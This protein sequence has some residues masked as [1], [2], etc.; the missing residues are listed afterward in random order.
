MNKVIAA[1]CIVVPLLGHV[2]AAIALPANEYACKVQTMSLLTGVVFVQA[3]DEPSAVMV[4]A[5]GNATRLDGVKEQV[6]A[7]VECIDYPQAR[8]SDDAL[9]AFIDAMPR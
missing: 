5:R 7:V 4:A 6:K 2:G 9:Q 8:F 1:V 3:D